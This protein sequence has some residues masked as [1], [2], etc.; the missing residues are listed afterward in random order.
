MWF[1][2]VGGGNVDWLSGRIFY[3][4]VYGS[5][6]TSTVPGISIAGPTPEATLATP[7]LDA[8][9]LVAGRPVSMDVVP[10]SP[11]GVPT[12]ALI[13]RAVLGLLGI[14]F[15]AVDSGS[16]YEAGVPHARLPGARAGGRIDVEP[17]LGKGVSEKIFSSARLLGE[18]LARGL[19]G[20]VIGESIP[21]GTTTAAA[22]V[23]ALGYR[24]LGRV[25]SSSPKN[26]SSLKE[27]VVKRA[28]GRVR[29]AEGVFEVLDEVGDPVHVALAGIADGAA[30]IGARVLLAGGT[31]M[32]APLAIL[33]RL[34]SKAI[35]SIAVGTTKW[36]VE[37]PSSDIVGLI[38]DVAPGVTL[39]YSELSLGESRF[40]GLKLYEEGY[41]K[42]GVGAGGLLVTAA[43]RGLSQNEVLDAIESLYGGLS[44]A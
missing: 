14:P 4:L 42:E 2:V 31:Q 22:I 8:E 15:L 38:G 3:V 19:D 35:E 23:E 24:G 6:R 43:V 27:G 25:S 9:V 39:T 12:P 20:V 11:E 37:D 18:T 44:K 5:T 28:L 41:A 13:S 7:S 29:R 32:A 40:E 10:V 33:A 36:I 17:G 1:N 30:S 26:P 21:G 34:E 16:A